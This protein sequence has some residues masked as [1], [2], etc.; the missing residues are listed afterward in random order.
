MKIISV[1]KLPD[2]LRLPPD[3]LLISINISMSTIL[4]KKA[5][6]EF[7][8]NYLF[9][10]CKVLFGCLRY[11][12]LLTNANGDENSLFDMI[13]QEPVYLFFGAV[14]LIKNVRNNLIAKKIHFLTPFRS[15]AFK[16]NLMFLEERFHGNCCMTYTTLINHFL[17]S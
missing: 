16:K 5:Q 6:R 13:I 4:K 7:S 9:C 12:K 10:R 14:H 11:K 17:L 15:M 2:D 1:F 8:I 3:C